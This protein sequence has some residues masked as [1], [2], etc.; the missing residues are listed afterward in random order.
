MQPARSNVGVWVDSRK[1]VVIT[2]SNGQIEKQILN[3]G[4]EA[5]PR[6]KGETSQ[7]HKRG[8]SGFDYESTQAN[9]YNEELKKFFRQ[10]AQSLEGAQIIYL[11]GPAEAK[12]GLEKAINEDTLLKGRIAEVEACDHMT[13]NQMVERVKNFFYHYKG[14]AASTAFNS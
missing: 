10:V 12:F 1:A 7:K 2:I 3:S 4:A 13:Q 5:K 14:L 11:F 9:H 8:F 6:F